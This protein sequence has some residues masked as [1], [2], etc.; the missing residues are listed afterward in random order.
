MEGLPQMNLIIASALLNGFP[1]GRMVKN[2]PARIGG[3]GDMG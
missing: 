2:L 3:T 1:G